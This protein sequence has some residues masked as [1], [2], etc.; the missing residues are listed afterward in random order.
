MRTIHLAALFSHPIQYFAPV[1]R[2]LD[3]RDG[4][5]LTV[6]YCSRQG[7]E[8]QTD[9]GFETDVAWDIPLLEGYESRFL[10]NV[11][12]FSRSSVVFDNINPEVFAAFRDGEY[13][14]I[15]VN[16]YT[17]L[18]NWFAF[19]GAT[20]SDV[21][22]VFRGAS[23]LQ[24]PPGPV[25]RLI[26]R[27]ILRTLFSRIDSF[28][29]VGTRNERF[30][31]HYG[32]PGE[33]IS[34]APNAVDN[35]FFQ[36][37]ADGLPPQD[38][39]RSELNFG[40]GPV[41][42]FVGKLGNHKRPGMLLR[43][44]HN[45]ARDDAKLVFAGEGPRRDGLEAEVVN[46]GLED[47]VVFSGFVNQ[48]KLPRYYAA[49]DILALP[50][51]RETWGLVINE[52]MNFSLPIVASEAVGAVPDLVDERNGRIVPTDDE[53]AL[54]DALET[55]MAS[56]DL[57]EQLANASYHRINDWGIEETVDGIVEATRRVVRKK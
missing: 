25:V 17:S 20:L 40:D 56:A 16:G 49:A 26:K 50:S 53:R 37:A 39:L 46:L 5:D 45:V 55:L 32:V 48:S 23:T 44:F 11:S 8:P 57:R 28:T 12:P 22:T 52:A 31:R 21:S 30:F 15:Y 33:K 6:Y 2:E 14:A 41:V 29:A 38:V 27:I 35:Q 19:L 4:I 3:D 43:A 18:T 7:L 36:E 42:L 34:I 1:F 54:A 10:D 47:D 9:A 51:I 13:D 24:N